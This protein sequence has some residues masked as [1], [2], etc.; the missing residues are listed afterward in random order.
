MNYLSVLLIKLPIG[1][2]SGDTIV[3]HLMYADDIL[4][5]APSANGLQR[6]LDISYNYGCDNDILF[7]REQSHLLLFY[8]TKTGVE[9]DFKLGDAVLNTSNSY[10]YLGHSL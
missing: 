7:I 9:V 6:L 2:C 10:K 4:L 3:S 8:T 5:L 1:C